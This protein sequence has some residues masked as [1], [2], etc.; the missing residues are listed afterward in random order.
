MT[1]TDTRQ[2]IRKLDATYRQAGLMSPLAEMMTWYVRA[3]GMP[4]QRLRRPLEWA[5]EAEQA[6]M[7]ILAN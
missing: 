5:M 2:M 7:D 1:S 4:T 3:E 6:G